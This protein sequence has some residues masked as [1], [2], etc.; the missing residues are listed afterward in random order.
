MNELQRLR[1][2]YDLRKLHLHQ[3]RN[4][5]MAPFCAASKDAEADAADEVP[6]DG[7]YTCYNCGQFR[8]SAF[9]NDQWYCKTNCEVRA[10]RG[11]LSRKRNQD[12]PPRRER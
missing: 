8:L 10:R 12:I 1:A 11:V 6:P 2:L 5:A 3:L 9:V 4:K 7:P